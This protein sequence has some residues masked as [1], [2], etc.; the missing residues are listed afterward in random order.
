[1]LWEAEIPSNVITPVE[2]STV[3]LIPSLAFKLIPISILFLAILLFKIIP[4]LPSNSSVSFL[5]LATNSLVLIIIFSNAFWFF[6]EPTSISSIFTLSAAL[7]SPSLVSFANDNEDSILIV[8]LWSAPIKLIS[9]PLDNLKISFLLLASNLI[10]VLA[11]I[12]LNAFWLTSEL[13]WILSNLILSSL[14]INPSLVALTDGI[15]LEIVNLFN[16]WLGIISIF[17]SVIMFNTS[18][19]NLAVRTPLSLPILLNPYWFSSALIF[20]LSNLILSS[21]LKYL[22]A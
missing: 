5:L 15:L 9:L 12:I 10:I 1:M 11:L 16:D 19:L 6:S 13:F 21:L 20:T 18:S 8:L 7:I 2:L 17:S 4:Y 14:V 3:L 22:S